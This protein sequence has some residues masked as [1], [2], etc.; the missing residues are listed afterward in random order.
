MEWKGIGGLFTGTLSKEGTEM[1]GTWKQGGQPL[2]LKFQRVESAE[3]AAK[4]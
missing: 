3:A 4:P 1:D 2:P